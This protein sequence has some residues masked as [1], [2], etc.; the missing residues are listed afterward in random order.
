MK[1][2]GKPKDKKVVG[3]RDDDIEETRKILDFLNEKLVSFQQ[4]RKQLR[5][6]LVQ[7]E[8]QLK[9]LTG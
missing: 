7:L 9:I 4:T 2:K 6:L 5:V 1:V 3:A 8:K